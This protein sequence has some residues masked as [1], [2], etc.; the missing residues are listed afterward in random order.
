M[1]FQTYDFDVIKKSP[2]KKIYTITQKANQQM[3]STGGSFNLRVTGQISGT[4]A[5]TAHAVLKDLGFG[6]DGQT[7]SPVVHSEKHFIL[8]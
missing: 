6:H 1:L 2:D 7:L 4:Q 3:Q 8:S 5:P